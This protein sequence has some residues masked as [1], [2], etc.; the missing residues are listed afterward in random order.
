[1]KL[2]KGFVIP[3]RFGVVLRPKKRIYNKENGRLIFVEILCTL[4]LEGWRSSTENTSTFPIR[5]TAS[6]LSTEI[7]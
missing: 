6:I 4:A 3:N 5:Q 2:D 1:M 7:F